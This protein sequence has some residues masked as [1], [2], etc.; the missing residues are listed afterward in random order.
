[1]IALSLLCSALLGWCEQVMLWGSSVC[2]IEGKDVDKP[3]YV[4]ELKG[5]LLG[6]L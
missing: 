2:T 5:N 1:M 3:V 6:I 4:S